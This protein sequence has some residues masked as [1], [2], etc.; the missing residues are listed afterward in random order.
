MVERVELSDNTL[1]RVGR[2]LSFAWMVCGITVVSSLGTPWNIGVLPL[3]GR[4]V[5]HVEKLLIS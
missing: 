4:K 3:T 1:V 5:T 2:A